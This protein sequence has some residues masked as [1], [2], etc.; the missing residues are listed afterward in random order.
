MGYFTGGITQAAGLSLPVNI[1]RCT[2][3]VGHHVACVVPGFE[4]DNPLD[5]FT[6]N[7]LS[8][9]PRWGLIILPFLPVLYRMHS[10]MASPYSELDI[11]SMFARRGLSSR[12]FGRRELMNHGEVGE[13]GDE[14]GGRRDTD[15]TLWSVKYPDLLRAVCDDAKKHKLVPPGSWSLSMKYCLGYCRKNTDRSHPDLHMGGPHPCKPRTSDPHIERIL[16]VRECTEGY[17]EFLP[18][19]FREGSLI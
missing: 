9:L 6:A 7:W 13:V 2:A 3:I 14:S 16:Q 18:P 11:R 17:L 12:L 5:P 1:S 8:F 15:S 10:E 19:N 4:K